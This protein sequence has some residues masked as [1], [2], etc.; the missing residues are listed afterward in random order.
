MK[1]CEKILIMVNQLN[2]FF[3]FRCSYRGPKGE[4]II[5]L[6]YS[7]YGCPVKWGELSKLPKAVFHSEL[8]KAVQAVF[9]GM[10]VPEPLDIVFKYWENTC[11]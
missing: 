3:S 1:I 11:W 9:P 5:Q 4:G 2:N 7:L 8:K 10:V 6:A